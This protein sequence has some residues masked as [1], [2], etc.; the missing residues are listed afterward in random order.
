M[1]I[2]TSIVAR[3]RQLPDAAATAEHGADLRGLGV[4]WRRVRFG[5]APSRN[6]RQN[7]QVEALQL[8][9]CQTRLVTVL[10]HPRTTISPCAASATCQFSAA[11][12]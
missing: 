7:L 1:L 3:R 12:G 6:L 4:Q 9:A 10:Q 11:V 8:K 5:Y 2:F